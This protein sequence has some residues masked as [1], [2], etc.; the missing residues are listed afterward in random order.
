MPQSVARVVL[1]LVYSRW[2]AG[3][4]AFSVSESK[5]PE[6]RRYIANQVEH[7]RGISF[8]DEFRKLC[9]RHG[10]TLDERYAWD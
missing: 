6:A 5:I 8:E 1:H 4:G 2:Q 9:I 10:I 3:Y 7:H